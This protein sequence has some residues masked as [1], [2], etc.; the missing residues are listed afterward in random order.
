MRR[1]LVVHT[2]GTLMMRA[3]GE[4]GELRPDAYGRDLLSELPILGRVADVSTHILFDLDSGDMQ[5]THWVEIARTV[6]AAIHEGA[7]DG[8]VVVHGTDTMAYAASAVAMLLGPLSRPVIFT[9][10]QRPLGELRTDARQ[11][12]VDAVLAATLPIPEVCVA[13]ASR[14]FRGARAMKR[15]ARALAAFDSPNCPPLAELGVD[16]EV[17]AHV[18]AAAT[19]MGGF[20]PRIEPR[21]L[22]VRVFPG[23]DPVLLR[24]AVRAGVRGLVLE[25]YG[26]GN[27]PHLTG[28]LIPVIEDAGARGVPVLVVSQCPRGVVDMGRYEGGSAAAAAGAIS[29]G[30]MT[31]EAALAKMMVGLGRF[32]SR[33]ALRAWIEQDWIGER[34]LLRGSADTVAPQGF[35]THEGHVDHPSGVPTQPRGA[36]RSPIR[37]TDSTTRGTSITHQGYRLNPRGQVDHPRGVSTQPTRSRSITLEGIDSNPRGQVDH[38]RGEYR[39]STHDGRI[40]EV[41]HQ[42]GPLN[43]QGVCRSPIRGTH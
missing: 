7:Y 33:E 32:E 35:L 22:A 25:A 20:D 34:E 30:D 17:A 1:I 26:T 29:G 13:F 11:N 12:L 5:P 43:P 15:D 37:G 3:S 19:E 39:L 21:V 31:T 10:A 40:S 2:G 18:R 38:P 42:A 36:R 6:H 14:V 4:T 8:V 28:S 9:G 16:V 27:L 23:L 24:G 41:T